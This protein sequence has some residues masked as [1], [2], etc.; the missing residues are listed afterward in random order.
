MLN[1]AFI[2]FRECIEISVM[3][4][5]IYKVFFMKADF[6][7][8]F[9]KGIVYGSVVSIAICMWLPLF[10]SYNL[11]FFKFITISVSAVMMLWAVVTMELNNNDND[12]DMQLSVFYIS[13]ITMFREIT[14]TFL[15]IIMFHYKENLTLIESIGAV[16]YGLVPGGILGIL[17]YLAI[18]RLDHPY[19]LRVLH[20]V[21]SAI[22]ANLFQESVTMIFEFYNIELWS[23]ALWNL[24]GILNEHTFP[25]VILSEFFGY[26][27]EPLIFQFVSFWSI[28]CFIYGYRYKFS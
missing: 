24:S 27:H 12:I 19:V 10:A 22:T 28:M 15:F 26:S 3:L 20:F 1:T 14:E 25:G 13:F 4:S 9:Y 2:V 16:F 6:K 23:S 7:K 8:N 21:L 18:I 17:S 11:D 5:A